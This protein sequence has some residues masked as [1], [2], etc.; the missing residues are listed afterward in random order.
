M[1]A[2]AMTKQTPSPPETEHGI[3]T[4]SHQKTL[5]DHLQDTIL[6]VK[7]AKAYYNQGDYEHAIE[8]S[9][10]ILAHE[11]SNIDAL[12]I[13]SYIYFHQDQEQKAIEYC[14]RWIA[15]AI[16]NPAIPLAVLNKIYEKK[17]RRE[18]Q[19]NQQAQQ[20]RLI[21]QAKVEE[22]NKVIADLSH[23]IKNLLSTVID[24]LENLKRSAQGTDR[25]IIENA[26]RGT[27]LV[28]EIVNG[29]NLSSQGD[30][31]DFYH[32]ARHNTGPNASNL[33]LILTEALKSAIANMFDGKYFSN[34]M[35]KYFP[36]KDLYLQAKSQ[37]EQIALINETK[38]IAAF[39]QE[40][41]FKTEI[42]WNEAERLVLGNDKGSATKL[43]ILC[44]EMLL[45]A[46]KY[47][48]FVERERR[49]LKLVF[50]VNPAQICIKIQNR[51]SPDSHIKTSGLGH[52]II[53]NFA[54]R[55]NASAIIEKNDDIYSIEFACVN[56]WEN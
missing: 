18:E 56:F 42:L 19:A 24:P 25:R 23:S 29:M 48:A 14:T 31:E 36:S 30:L 8:C 5:P 50:T 28:R 27:N 45:N 47:S 41:F 12:N 37:W 35:R 54:E 44:Q 1:T 32:D 21:E 26:L 16:Q 55:M 51:F 13:L 53:E 43:L 3:E 40:Y 33:K 38:P 22:R 52:V 34:F 11:P 10:N 7:H 20:E 6:L 4:P 15:G 17:A 46:I 9:Q 39:L 49:V 2:A